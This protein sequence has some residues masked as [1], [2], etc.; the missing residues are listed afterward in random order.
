MEKNNDLK[1]QKTKHHKK[2]LNAWHNMHRRV[3]N[4]PSYDGV[5]ICDEWYIYSNFY[6]WYE[7]HV[8]D[9][10]HIDKDISGCHKY[11]PDTCVFVPVEVNML[12][13]DMKTQ[14]MKGVVSN[15]QGYQSQISV[16]GKI[17]KL[18]TFDTI[19]KAHAAYLNARTERLHELVI[20]YPVLNSIL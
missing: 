19:E 4:D 8:V 13:R 14:F 6:S 3:R 10:W 11:S 12:F 18:G 7:E 20:K 16:D 9:G 5:T 15:T 17:K 2:A 1:G